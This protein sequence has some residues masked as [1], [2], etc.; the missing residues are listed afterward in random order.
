MD[1]GDDLF[2]H[3]SAL[4]AQGF[5]SLAEGE[6]LEFD[7]ENQGNGKFRA[8][9]VT[10]PDGDYVKGDGG[11]RP[12]GGGCDYGRGRDSRDRDYGGGGR[13]Y[14]RRGGGRGRDRR[15]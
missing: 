5:R 11:P 3:Q 15:R 13:D 12:R 14:E 4:H 7:V 6:K 8:I 10:G 9:N 1:G 2:V